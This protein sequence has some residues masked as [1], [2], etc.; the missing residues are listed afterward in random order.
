MPDKIIINTA[1]AVPFG[2][3]YSYFVVN[4]ETANFQCSGLGASDV[5]QI[6]NDDGEPDYEN[7]NKIEFT[8]TNKNIPVRGP[9]KVYFV[10]AA[11]AG[12]VKVK[13]IEL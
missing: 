6:Y 5:V 4:G 12:V 1:S 9:K 11:T 10:K 2:D 8:A 7:D 3:L 13:K